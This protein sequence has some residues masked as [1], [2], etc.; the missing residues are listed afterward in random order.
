MWFTLENITGS[1]AITGFQ[2]VSLM[3]SVH[4]L[5]YAAYFRF[6]YVSIPF[7]GTKFY[8]G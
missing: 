3:P 8:I 1:S 2:N 5:S 6:Y 7:L 4:L